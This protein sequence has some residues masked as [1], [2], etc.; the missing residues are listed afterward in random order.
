MNTD[1]GRR[2][3]SSPDESAT[4]RLDDK[5]RKGHTTGRLDRKQSSECVGVEKGKDGR[6]RRRNI[7]VFG[8]GDTRRRAT[9]PIKLI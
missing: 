9:R 8:G 6:R 1:Q 7:A 4:F 3:K 2:H 5:E